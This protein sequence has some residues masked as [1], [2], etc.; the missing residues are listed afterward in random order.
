MSTLTVQH[1]IIT[2]VHK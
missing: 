2:D 1:H